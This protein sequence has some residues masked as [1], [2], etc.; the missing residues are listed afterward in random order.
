MDKTIKIKESTHKRL[1]KYGNKGESF[2]DL[3]NRLLNEYDNL[4]MIISEKNRLRR[5]KR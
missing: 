1:L 5:C 4:N 3:F 2:D